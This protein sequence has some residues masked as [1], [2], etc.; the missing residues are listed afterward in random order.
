VTPHI[1]ASDHLRR[2]NPLV[3]T[4]RPVRTD[5]DPSRS[6]RF[7]D[8]RW[9]LTPGI[10][11]NHS[12]KVSITF[13][14]F[15]S[16]WRSA[17]KEYFWCLINDETPRPLPAAQF[18]KRVS[19]RTIS[20]ARSPL[21][22]VLSWAE[23]HGVTRL[24][25][26]STIRFDQMLHDI[27]ALD[28]SL[29]S[30]GMM[31]SETRRLW[32]YRDA[33][34]A[35]LRLPERQPWLGELARD[36]FEQAPQR[37]GNRVP[38]INDATLVPLVS[39]AARFVDDLSAD[40]TVSFREYC[41][42]LQQEERHRPL[43]IGRGATDGSRRQRLV[44]VLDQL[45]RDGIKL[46]GH[47]LPDGSREIRWQHLGRLTFTQGIAHSQ[48][49]QDLV[50][51]SGLAIDDNTYLSRQ[52]SGSI[53]GRLWRERP[54]PFDDAKGFA[55]HLVTACFILIAYL[56]GMRPGEVLSLE[57]DCVSHDASAG[58]WTV[59]GVRWKGARDD[60]GTK[61][62]EG[63]QRDHPWV[64]HPI[65]ARAITVLTELHTEEL[66][67]PLGIR[68]K[69]V[70]S[71]TGP[72]NLR[73]GQ[74]MT[75]SQIGTDIVEFMAWVN[76]YC[77]ETGRPD[78][79]PADGHGRVSPRRFRRTLAWHIVRQPRGLV[80]AAIQYGHVA[81]RITQGYA[82]TYASGFLDDLALER[83]LERIEDVEELES[84]LDS[85]GRVS[86]P[87]AAE[88]ASRTRRA[89]AR[90]VGRSIPTGRQ[91]DK[92][93]QDPVLQV[94]KGRGMHCVFHKPSALCA[95]ESDEG[96]SLGDCRSACSN[97][98]RTDGDVLELRAEVEALPED[99]LA[100]AIRHRRI[101]LV[102]ESLTDAITRHEGR[103]R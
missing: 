77:K 71:T 15:P 9:D 29:N 6:S 45:R 10:F 86:G 27:A 20:F 33:V 85:G 7:T 88:L 59:A 50:Q 11:E 68:P 80:A 14:V 23:A 30:K 36:L 31:V 64:V 103:K 102:K 53:D 35:V 40:I 39:W 58:R 95:K 32:A 66:L 67:F 8:D 81:T 60:D 54:I 4:N 2:T 1:A 28:L 16:R 26:L 44:R 62:V 83:W 25:E 17:V 5:I 18:D 61:A 55:Q 63:E 98:A 34:P 42:F 22:K 69:P 24:E 79:I 52:C 38:R 56:S 93:L 75:T 94:F 57:R 101:E 82:G 51:R 96:P 91:A 72:V 74:A 46:P 3:L 49:D 13:E 47:S 41:L 100:P 21:A 99:P 12:T 90:F 89:K 43:G 97:I 37:S 48:Y 19:L 76:E 65:V 73:P 87:S 84:Y 92:L 78:S 70:R